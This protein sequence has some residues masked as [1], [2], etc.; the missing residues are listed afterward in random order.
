[1]D[2][3]EIVRRRRMVRNFS[4]EP[5]PREVLERI[6]ERAQRT[7][8]AGFSQG[9]RLLVVT[10]PERRRRVGGIV[11]EA[12]YR[13]AGYASWISECAAQFIPCVS[14]EAYHRRYREADKVRPD[15]SEIEWPVPYWWIDA[16]FTAL[17]ILLAAV[18][19]G[20]A[21]GYAGVR[22]QEALRGELAIPAEFTAIGVI[23]LGH[24]L[25]DHRSPSLKR[26][27][28]ARQEFTHW[29]TW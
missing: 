17:M 19:E 20:L 27:W 13:E 10:D 5:V 2:F 14:E 24:P 29:E 25:P 18:D 1:M 9:Q 22:N 12:H 15:G 11:D 16:G 8:S 28:V 4:P 26:G 23:P 7:P 6:A 21:A 3:S